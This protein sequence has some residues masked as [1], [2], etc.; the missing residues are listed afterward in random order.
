M[1]ASSS[2]D[3]LQSPGDKEHVSLGVVVTEMEMAVQL[4]MTG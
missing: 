4:G 3:C 2:A 1:G